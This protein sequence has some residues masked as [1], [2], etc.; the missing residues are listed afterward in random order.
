MKPI[1][2]FIGYDPREAIA[3]HTCVNS[4]IRHASQPVS[5]MPLALNNFG[6]YTET[7]TD[8]SNQFIYSRFLVPHLMGYSGHAIFMDGDMI[9][10]GDIAELWA[11]RLLDKDV[12]VVKHDYKTRM[13]TKYLGSKNEDYPRKNWSSVMIFNCNNYPTRKLTPEYIQKSTGAHLHRFQWT[14]DDR[15]GTLPAEWNWLP[16]EYGANP[17]AKLLH[18][19]L[20]TPCFH[21]F[22]TTPM[23]DEWHRERMLT[24]YCLQREI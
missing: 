18:Y 3:F 10:R 19:T 24:E 23:A 22:A 13:T 16:D 21:E 14:S 15:V 12:Q 6:D 1:P 4:I 17:D 11:M 8:G 2:I 7:H 20:G 9:V 5:I